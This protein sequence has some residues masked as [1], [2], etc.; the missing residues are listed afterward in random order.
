KLGIVE[1]HLSFHPVTTFGRGKTG[2]ASITIHKDRF[3][4]LPRGKC[5][6][7]ELTSD[8]ASGRLTWK[9][10]FTEG[11]P[12]PFGEFRPTCLMERVSKYLESCTEPVSRNAVLNDVPGKDAGKRQAIDCLIREGHV[13]AE[14]GPRNSQLLRS[15]RPYRE[16]F[17]AESSA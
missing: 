14:P 2:K 10:R 12:D 16:E 6:E 9:I 1:A 13:E 3:G 8:A 4:H 17:D 15:V 5:A 7:L 11:E